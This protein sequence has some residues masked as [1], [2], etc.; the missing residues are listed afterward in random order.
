ME[1]KISPYLINRNQCTARPDIEKIPQLCEILHTTPDVLFG[2]TGEYPSVNEMTMVRK[3][4]K[5][6]EIGKK[7]VDAVLNFEYERAFIEQP[8]KK[9]ARMLKLDF[10]N[11]PA[12][13][14]TGSF[15]ETEEPNEIRVLETPE[16]ENT[17]Y[18]IPISGESMNPSFHDGDGVF[19]EKCD[20]VDV[21]EIEIFVVNGEAYIKELGDRCLISHNPSYKPI[22]F[23]HDNSIY[24]CGKV[25]GIVEE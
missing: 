20:S 11:F 21:G 10:D 13:A 25:I 8:K 4:R 14:G 6:D 9:R 12:S 24:C 15:L 7:A 1:N 5:L 19:V 16:A 17:D 3:Y 18:I 23:R 22:P 2:V